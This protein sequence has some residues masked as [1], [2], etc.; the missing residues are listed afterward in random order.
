MIGRAP[1]GN[2]ARGRI[3][4]DD[5]GFL[6]LI[7]RRHDGKLLGVHAIGEMATELVHIG[8]I[9]LMVGG[10]LTLFDETCFNIPTLGSLYKL[11]ALNAVITARG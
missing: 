6:K 11:A 2:S 1:Y 9:A 8:L 4:G 10:S 7:F 5:G 3:I